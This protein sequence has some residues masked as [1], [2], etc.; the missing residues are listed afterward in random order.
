M[1]IQTCPGCKGALGPSKR[2]G[3]HTC[4]GCGGL[5]I[6][7]F[8]LRA[9][10]VAVPPE[11]HRTLPRTPRAC[12]ICERHME[13][14][15]LSGVTLDCCGPCGAL[16]F[17]AGELQALRAAG[18]QQGEVLECDG[19]GRATPVGELESRDGK[20]LCPGCASADPRLRATGLSDR[21]FSA[22]KRHAVEEQDN[23]DAANSAY[24]SRGFGYDRYDNS[25]PGL[26]Q[27]LFLFFR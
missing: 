22:A 12:P 11:L 4:T 14:V 18:P 23:I 21:D 1:P 10:N 3:A 9:L 16:Y 13:Q 15:V 26:L 24:R 8:A 27:A 5:F 20:A 25:G 19:C 6:E 7:A 2:E 17:D